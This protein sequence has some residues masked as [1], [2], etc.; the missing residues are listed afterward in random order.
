MPAR[1]AVASLPDRT[2]IGG[3]SLDHKRG[4]RELGSGRVDRNPV[5]CP[6]TALQTQWFELPPYLTASQTE[7]VMVEL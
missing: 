2:D 7:R 5:L 6:V 1:L 3:L 4:V